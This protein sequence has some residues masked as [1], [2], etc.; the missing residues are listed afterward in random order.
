MNSEFSAGRNIYFK[1]WSEEVEYRSITSAEWHIF[2]IPDGNNGDEPWKLLGTFPDDKIITLELTNSNSESIGRLL[3]ST[4]VLPFEV[5]SVL[6][7]AALMGAIIIARKD[8]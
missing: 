7:L 3:M 8:D 2:K 4:F 5:V 6:L 1:I